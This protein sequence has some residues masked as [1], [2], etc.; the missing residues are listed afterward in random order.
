MSAPLLLGI[1]GGGTTTTAWLTDESGTVLGR[2]LAGPSNNK[3]V[4][5]DRARE[6]LNQAIEHAFDDADLS[7]RPVDVACFGLAGYDRPGDKRQLEEWSAASRWTK[8][9]VLVNDGDLVLAVGTPDYAG[10]AV[11]AGTGSIAVGRNRDGRIARAGGWG[12][13]LGDEGSAYAVALAG[14]R[15]AVRRA[16]GRDALRR[17]R[18]KPKNDALTSNS[19]PNRRDALTERLCHAL[20]ILG[21]EHFIAAV[22]STGLDRTQIAALAPAVVAAAVDD[23]DVVGWIL[24]PAGYEL[25][26]AVQAVA[27][28]LDWQEPLLPLAMAGGFLLSA[29]PVLDAMIGYLQKFGGHELATATV[30]EPVLGAVLLARKVLD[31]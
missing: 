11:I 12:Y 16:D 22:Y 17:F 31:A 28:A 9:L 30:P 4:T 19:R 20:G 26:Q 27:L 1:D 21:P 29:R 10:V 2:G 7:P 3:A 14:L 15:L 25:G 24:E 13:L 8:R 6:A 18:A 5:G 23:P